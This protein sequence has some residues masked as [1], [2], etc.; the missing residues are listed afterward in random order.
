MARM[1]RNPLNGHTEKVFGDS[2][3]GVLF[4]GPVYLLVK[5]LWTHVLIWLI[6][7]VLAA[8]LGGL[9][10]F[11]VAAIILN[12]G[13][14][15]GIHRI[16]TSYYLRNGWIETSGGLAITPDS[17]ERACPLCAETIKSAAIK[18][19]HC[20]ADVEQDQ[21]DS[22]L[23]PLEGWVVRIP[24]KV[25]PEFDEAHLLLSKNGY[26]ILDSQDEE[27]VVGPYSDRADAL[28][29]KKRIGFKYAL[30]GDVAWTPARN[31]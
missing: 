22:Q 5:G 12:L 27:L 10:G 6:A 11:V 19:K 3:V 9:A 4:F 25:G 8:A 1:F 16:L 18:C 2:W 14:T 30:H 24:F 21:K 29:S 31:Q 13:Y 26:Q 28:K 7:A 15:V 23:G 17:A 20:G